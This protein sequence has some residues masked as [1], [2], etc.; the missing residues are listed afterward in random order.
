MADNGEE[1]PISAADVIY[2]TLRD[3]RDYTSRGWLMKRVG[4]DQFS[5]LDAFTRAT[6]R[7]N[8]EGITIAS[9]NGMLYQTSSNQA[10]S[11]A[12]GQARR[13]RKKIEKIVQ[14][15]LNAAESA[16][17]PLDK[18]RMEAA[19]LRLANQSVSQ[20]SYLRDAL[21]RRPKGT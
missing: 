9:K 21:K 8:R 11:R 1:E 12:F 16:V 5:F 2:L 20:K 17:D 6:E 10:A 7:L 13:V 15:A 4:L 18:E 3:A 14:T 19:A